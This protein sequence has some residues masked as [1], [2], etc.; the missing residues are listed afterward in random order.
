M[1]RKVTTLDRR[2]GLLADARARLGA[3][4]LMNVQA[5]VAD[6]REGWPDGAPYD[7][8]VVNAFA[9]A[10]PPALL[11]QLTP[12]GRLVMPIAAQ[13]DMRLK[14]FRTSSPDAPED[15]GRIGDFPRLEEAVAED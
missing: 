5:H 15:L 12:D 9:E 8:I 11:D 1:A 4:R 2:R 10:P 6:G 13:G 7:R 14:R 3:L